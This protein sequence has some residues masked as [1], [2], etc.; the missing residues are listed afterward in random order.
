MA[1]SRRPP[2]RAAR[3]S[4]AAASRPRRRPRRSSDPLRARLLA[5]AL[6][7]FARHGFEGASTRAIAQRARAHQPQ[8]NYH[9]ASKQELWKAAVD[10]LFAR[11]DAIVFDGLDGSAEPAE[12]LATVVRR[13]V[14]FAARHPELNRIMVQEATAATAR[15]GWIVERHVR[16]RYEAFLALWRRVRAA[17]AA[18]PIDERVAYHAFVGAASLVYANAP[19]ARRLLGREPSDPELLEAHADALVAMLLP[20]HAEARRPESL[21]STARAARP[22]RRITAPPEGGV[23]APA[24]DGRRNQ[25]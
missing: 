3:P 11:L 1:R 21:G 22:P 5:A 8:I 14:R 19:E 6:V 12:L 18:A 13:F 7:E 2:P 16:P 15:V 9:F 20:G 24:T 17:G 23:R 4:P 25:A 10:H